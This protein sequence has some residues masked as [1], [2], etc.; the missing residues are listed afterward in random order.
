MDRII[1]ERPTEKVVIKETDHDHVH[2][3]PA[4]NN[5][6]VIIAVVVIIL[7]LIV[8]FGRGLFGGSGNGDNGGTNVAPSTNTSQ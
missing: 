6:A 5:T 4:R 8:L 1:E 3:A 7:L 2:D